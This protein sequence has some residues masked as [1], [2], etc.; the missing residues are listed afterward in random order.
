M[1][2]NRCGLIML[3]FF[4]MATVNGHSQN[5]TNGSY[6]VTVDMDVTGPAAFYRLHSP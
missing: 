2:A 6:T 3:A 5:L 4:F 1:R